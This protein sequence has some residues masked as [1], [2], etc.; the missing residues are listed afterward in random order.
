[1]ACGDIG[2]G[3]IRTMETERQWRQQRMGEIATRKLC[4]LR[5]CR[6][7]VNHIDGGRLRGEQRL[8]LCR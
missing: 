8:K 2:N 7:K 4:C 5:R 1:M 3:A 6:T